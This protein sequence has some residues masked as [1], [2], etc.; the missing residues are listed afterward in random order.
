MNHRARRRGSRGQAMPLVG[1]ILAVVTGF[2]ALGVDLGHQFAQKLIGQS[3][4][5]SAAISAAY[6]LEHNPLHNIAGVLQ[7]V[8][9]W[10]DASVAAAHDYVAADGFPTAWPTTV[11]TACLPASHNSLT[12]F[13]EEFF[14]ASYHGSCTTSPSG[15]ASEVI[16]NVP[17]LTYGGSTLPNS[18][19]GVLHPP[20]YPYNCIQV[21]VVQR[22][23]NFIMQVFGTPSEDLTT[24][25]TGFAS[26]VVGVSL[27]SA[28]AVQLYEKTSCEATLLGG[29]TCVLP[30]TGACSPGSPVTFQ[31]FDENYAPRKTTPQC[32][33][34]NDNCPTLFAESNQDAYIE[35]ADGTV[36]APGQTHIP[37]VASA[38]DI[39]DQ[40]GH[41]AFCDAYGYTTSSPP[42][43]CTASA[44]ATG[45]TAFML[46]AGSALYC[47]KISTTP[48]TG[49]GATPSTGLG[50]T[51]TKQGIGL[52]S[53]P[54][55]TNSSVQT[56]VGNPTA[57][58]PPNAWTPIAP[59]APTNSCGG[60]ILNGDPITASNNPP[61]FFDSSGNPES[62]VPG[63]CVPPTNEEFTIEPGLYSYIVVNFGRYDF[64]N[65]FFE[66]SGNAP[67]NT[68]TPV[69]DSREP[70]GIDHSQETTTNDWDL[71]QNAT[72]G[73]NVTGCSSLTAGIWI[74]HGNP[75]WLY[76]CKNP[77]T[78]SPCITTGT[79]CGN[80]SYTSGNIGGGGQTTL[81]TGVA[82]SFRFDA[83]SNGFV[84][85][86]EASQVEIGGPAIGTMPQVSGVPMLFDA[87]NPNGYMHLDGPAG[88]TQFT[89][90]VYEASS[91]A[92]GSGGVDIE[93]GLGTNTV[94]P[95]YATPSKATLDGQV[96]AYS[97]SLFGNQK[98]TA[99]DFS[100][101]WGTGTS[102]PAGAGSDESSLI[103]IPALSFQ[104]GSSPGTEVLH[105]QYNDEWMMDA[106]DL[107]VSI[108]N[109]SFYFSAGLWT[110][111]PPNSSTT[112]VPPWPP[113]N[114]YKPS[115]AAPMY[116]YAD[117]VLSNTSPYPSTL[118]PFSG[119]YTSGTAYYDA[120]TLPA[121]YSAGTNGY[122]D[123]L[124]YDSDPG[125]PDDVSIDVSGDWTWGNQ[126]NI[127]TPP[128]S[129][130]Q[131]HSR[132]DT[133]SADIYVTM[134]IPVGATSQIVVHAVDGDHCGDYSNTSATLSNI[135][136]GSGAASNIGATEL[137][138]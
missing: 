73:D 46:A 29:S 48:S 53:P 106:Y 88:K 80:G 44:P 69:S 123:E 104:A 77:Q 26:P 3:A 5:D 39:V 99:V 24:V 65:G 105:L 121:T 30:A 1:L 7:G 108:N 94:L 20:G 132:T 68:V 11:A 90:L 118:T 72:A 9:L 37:A 12:Q 85:T 86:G 25:A 98:G 97:L 128:N 32:T 84:S 95:G 8:P 124:V 51:C 35:G 112:P 54:A 127:P 21:V 33:G 82:T 101:Y 27:P 83:G 110:L 58:L 120:M 56:V 138:Q 10:N 78:G 70:N 76:G 62:S 111:N 131:G 45:S 52:A 13:S 55:Y 102:G 47:S 40:A 91:G 31:C 60:L 133:Y 28:T 117:Q 107:S 59:P 4:V 17:P 116:A 93:P 49:N 136:G 18:C 130:V 41:L 23:T 71:C 2:V 89:G 81:V 92:A 79:T 114:G 109:K 38:G 119:S 19:N 122:F 36:V 96:I 14:D 63:A 137:V 66:I 15:F 42:I 16:V 6:Q 75:G 125:Q 50:Q 43:Q 126:S 57:Y 34:S 134:P 103:T 61:V 67:V 135:A 113:E 129:T 100:G 115:D 74:G 64:E 22:L 87:E